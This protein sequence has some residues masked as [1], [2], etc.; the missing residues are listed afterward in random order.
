MVT[1]HEF[2]LYHL[3]RRLLLLV[4]LLAGMVGCVI[5]AVWMLGCILFMPYG[6][7]PMHIAIAFDQL[8]NAVTGGSEDETI[9]S[10]AGR[11]RKQGRGWACVLC[12]ALDKLE[13]NHCDNSIGT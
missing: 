9:S 6:P 3:Q 4:F 7:R 1:A 12:R 11:L 13:K 5:A 10:R 8:V 2:W